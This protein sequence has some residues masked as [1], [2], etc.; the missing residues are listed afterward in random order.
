MIPILYK[1]VSEGTVPSNYGVGALTD[2]IS[3]TVTEERNGA[4]EL[5]LTYPANGIHAED[6]EPNA[7][8]KAKPNFMDDPQ[9][10]RIIKVSATIAGKFTV[11]A[12]HI[13]YDL[14][15]KI[16]TSGTAGSCTAACALLQTKAGNFSITTDRI[17]AGAFSIAEPSSVRSWFGGKAGSLLDIYGGEW[18]YDNYGA[19]LMTSRGADRGVTIR[20][21]KN[22]TQ[23]SQVLDMSNLC[24][25]IVPFYI[26]QNGNKTVGARVP[27]GLTLD[28]DRDLAVD[29]SQQ[30]QP[31]DNTPITTQLANLAAAY[32]SGNEFTTIGKSITLDFV[33]TGAITERVD[34]CDTV[35]IYFEPLGI[36]AKAKCVKTVWDVLEGRYTKTTFGSARP[37]IADTIAQNKKELETA[38]SRADVNRATELITGNRGG[39]VILHDSD[40]DDLPDE[41]L[42]MNTADINTATQV[43][44]W[45]KSGLGYSDTGY[46]GPYGLAM[47]KE[48]EINADFL[49]VG[50]IQDRQGN[51]QIDM[52][53][54]TASLWT[55]S[56][57]GSFRIKNGTSG[58]TLG[59][60]FPYNA[61]GAFQLNNANEE[62]RANLFVNAAGSYLYLYEPDGTLLANLSTSDS[63][64][65]LVLNNTSGTKNIDI[66]SETNS[67]VISIENAAGKSV[68]HGWGNPG[69]WFQVRDGLGNTTI[70]L[71]GNNGGIICVSVT[72]TSSRKVKK[73]ITELPEEEAEA[74][75]KLQAV[76]FDYK[77]EDQGKDKRG[78]IAEDVAEIIPGLVTPETENTPAALDYIGMVPYIQTV[79]KAQ[80]RRLQEQE[81]RIQELE[82]KIKDITGG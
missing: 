73:N 71:N 62:G 36:S 65:G 29:F 74:I 33:Q 10:F 23:L 81:E 64:A 12:Q 56:A 58:K 24:T 48:G 61:G 2:A 47:T 77:N 75:L 15:G 6:I 42:I 31:E 19:R 26:D 16:I 25:G 35:S 5:A 4:Y 22:L 67:G 78:F 57:K 30:V 20:Y 8:I 51:S 46:A 27:T 55:L 34:L 68:V 1:T 9:L 76:R 52:T 43:W 59:I 37:N 44:R 70:E 39:Y 3:A 80:E 63:G 32:I 69:G 41:I 28:A 53:N 38:A 66:H 14:S 50:V 17:K 40:G 11:Q 82:K 45:N 60:Y 49:K 79:L 54:G 21:G 7:F 18:K 13:S 72:Q